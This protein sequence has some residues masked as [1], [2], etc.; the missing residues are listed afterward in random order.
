MKFSIRDLFLVT[1]IVALVLG[2]GID[3]RQQYAKEQQTAKDRDHALGERKSLQQS[4]KE[5]GFESRSTGNGDEFIV[6]P[7][8]P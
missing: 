4:L 1:V 2:W 3:H 7:A 8:R 6:T 5:H